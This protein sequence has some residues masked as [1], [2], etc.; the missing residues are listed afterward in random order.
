MNLDKIDRKILKLIQRDASL[1]ASEIAEQVNLSQ[2]PCWRRIK[3]LED[4]GYI[5]ARVGLL[6]RQKLGLNTVIYT[7]VKLTANG[8]QELHAFEERIREVPEVTECYVML[9]RVD[10][11]LCIVTKDMEHYER[12]Y[13]DVLSQ[14]PGV[15]EFNSSVAM[16]EIKLSTELPLDAI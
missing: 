15:Q 7:E 11:L 10:F 13:R 8:R 6:N 12:L 5:R 14:L 2:P 9:G 4:E 1:T 3:R 16:S